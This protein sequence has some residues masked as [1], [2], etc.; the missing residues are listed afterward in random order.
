MLEKL[1]ADSIAGQFDEA[2]LHLRDEPLRDV[3][4]LGEVLLAPQAARFALLTDDGRRVAH[5]VSLRA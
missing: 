4:E 1:R 3:E 2:A 5:T